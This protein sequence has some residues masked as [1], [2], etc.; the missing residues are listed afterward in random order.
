M[1]KKY[2]N[3]GTTSLNL[4]KKAGEDPCA[5]SLTGT[6]NTAISSMVADCRCFTRNTCGAWAMHDWLMEDQSFV[7]SMTCSL[8]SGCQ[9][10]VIARC[11]CINSTNCIPL[12]S[13]HHLPL[14]KWC[15]EYDAVSNRHGSL[16]HTPRTACS[17]TIKS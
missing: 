13:N 6:R 14:S 16:R 1:E 5:V 12:L 3:M 7:S 11:R 15:E 10:A 2:M 9:Q 8:L 4:L 17:I